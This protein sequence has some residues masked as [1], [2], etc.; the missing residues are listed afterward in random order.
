M[1]TDKPLAGLDDPRNDA[2]GAWLAEERRRI[3]ARWHDAA[4]DRLAITSCWE[5]L[6]DEERAED[7]LAGVTF[8]LGVSVKGKPEPLF[9]L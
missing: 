1:K 6:S 7:K 8:D 2:L 3:E 5:G 9:K 4:L